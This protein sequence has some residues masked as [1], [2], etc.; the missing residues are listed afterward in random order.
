MTCFPT[1][2]RALSGLTLGLLLQAC[3]QNPAADLLPTASASRPDQPRPSLPVAV[4][5]AAAQQRAAAPATAR[6]PAAGEAS[7]LRFEQAW[8]VVELMGQPRL[9]GG[10]RP[11]RVVLR[12]QG[13]LMVDGGCNHFSG[14]VERDAQGLFR[15]SKYGGTHGGCDEPSRAEALLNSALM[16]VDNFRWDR[17]LLLRSGETELL[18]LQPSANQDSAELEQALVRRP[19]PAAAPEAAPVVCRPVKAAKPR[20]GGKART[21]GAANCQ[22]AK[23]SAARSNIKAVGKSQSRSAKVRKGSAKPAG[24][25]GSKVSAHA[26]VKRHK[27]GH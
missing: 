18:R 24:K 4:P 16:M 20:K 15:V 1:A 12:P 21:K 27:T 17:G 26:S 10:L 14:R 9:A 23:T 7:P 25:S 6:L 5:A 11:P 2:A 13:G 8:D 22:P 3:A 19:V